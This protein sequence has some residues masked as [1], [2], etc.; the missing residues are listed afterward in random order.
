[1][2]GDGHTVAYVVESSSVARVFFTGPSASDSRVIF[3]SYSKT[4]G[5]SLHPTVRVNRNGTYLLVFDPYVPGGGAAYIVRTSDG[6]QTRVGGSTQSIVQLGNFY[7]F[8]PINDDFYLQAQVGG[9][10]PPMS[11]S[12]YLTL[13]RGSATSAATL[14]QVGA[15]YPIPSNGGGSGM[16]V[17]ITANGR[18]ALH[19]E[20]I[21]SPSIKSSVLVYDSVLDT[22]TPAYRRPVS[23]EIGMWNG[24][25]LSNDSS[26]V[27]FQFREPGSGSFGPTRFFAGSPGA[28]PNFAAVTPL[29]DGGYKC[30]FGWDNRTL[31]YLANTAAEPRQQM[32]WVDAGAPGTPVVVNRP[33]VNGEQME[34]WWVAR[35]SP[36]LVFGTRGISAQ[37]DFYSVSLDAPGTFIPFATNVFDDGSL[38][39]EIDRNG[40]VLAYA[41]RPAPLSGLRRLTLLSTQTAGYSFSLT[42]L[43]TSTGLQ[44]FQW[45]P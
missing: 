16:E 12:G 22:E 29:V 42:R 7:A 4:P 2:A 10:P 24:F 31:F 3:T 21:Y 43:D 38:P 23:G 6:L 8:N 34:N 19:Q 9:S 5:S 36:R 41:K 17:A 27:C 35:N 11:G 33:Y 13:F 1:M 30:S 25:A 40:F 14:T 28:A 26:R 32:Y 44:Q 15:V 39:G 20:L 18:Y 37:V 45:A